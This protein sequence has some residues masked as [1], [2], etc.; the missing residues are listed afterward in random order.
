MAV[1]RAAVAAGVDHIKTV[2][3]YGPDIVSELIR[4]ALNP[5]PP[6]LAILSKVA[7]Q[8]LHVKLSDHALWM[9]ANE[10]HHRA[11]SGEFTGGTSFGIR[12][13]PKSSWRDPGAARS[14]CFPV[15]GSPPGHL[16]SPIAMARFC[17]TAGRL[18]RCAVSKRGT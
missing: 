4:D 3:Y 14:R 1:L 12:P 15:R 18:R 7:A 9:S 11:A 10:P 5:Y 6:E 2:Q 13:A 17:Q 8:P 16:T